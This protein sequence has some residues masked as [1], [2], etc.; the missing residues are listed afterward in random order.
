MFAGM[1]NGALEQ[2]TAAKACGDATVTAASA[3]DASTAA[4]L[5]RAL[6]ADA[7]FVSF[8]EITPKIHVG[9]LCTLR[10]WRELLLITR[11]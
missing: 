4:R 5:K 1:P 10:N 11:R 8:I 9:K 7:F 3:K 6:R 2:I